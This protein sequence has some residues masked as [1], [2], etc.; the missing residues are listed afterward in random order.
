MI[1]APYGRRK[2]EKNY[3][4][5]SHSSSPI[6]T[7]DKSTTLF[8]SAGLVMRDRKVGRKDTVVRGRGLISKIGL[9]ISLVPLV[10]VRAYVMLSR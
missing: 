7:C 5:E 1:V 4:F 10:V 9:N 6:V 8:S 3:I 2:P